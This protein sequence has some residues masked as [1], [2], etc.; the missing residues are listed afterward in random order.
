ME[1]EIHDIPVTKLKE[2][3]RNPRKNDAA[4]ES[5]AAIAE[6]SVRVRALAILI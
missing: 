2:Y 6:V 1:M 5:V 4:V 3:G